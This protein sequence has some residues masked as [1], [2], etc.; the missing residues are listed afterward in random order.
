MTDAVSHSQDR[1][2]RAGAVGQRGTD[3]F[4]LTGTGGLLNPANDF[5]S[6]WQAKKMEAKLEVLRWWP[7]VR[8]VSSSR[9]VFSTWCLAVV[10]ATHGCS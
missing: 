7:Q 8:F 1:S 10:Q 2:F 9:A 4:M 6:D 3:S 5:G